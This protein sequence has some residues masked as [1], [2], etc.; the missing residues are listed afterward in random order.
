MTRTDPRKLLAAAAVLVAVVAALVGRPHRP[1]GRPG[2]AT[3]TVHRFPVQAVAFSPDGATLTTAAFFVGAGEADVT[4]WDVRAGCPAAR[5]TLP[6]GG[7][8]CLAFAPGGRPLAAA[9]DAL[10]V[11][12]WDA[13]TGDETRLPGPHSSVRALAFSG[14]GGRLAAADTEPEGGVAVSVV[15]GD[16]PG[17]RCRGPHGRV[18][19]LAFSPDGHTLAGGECDGEPAV[20]L[21]DAGTG[22]ERAACRGHAAGVTAVAFA[23]DGR[24]LASG[25]LHGVV[26]LWDAGTGA[27]RATLTAPGGEAVT[28]V[29]F[30]PDGRT[31]AVAA[32]R[33]V[34]LWDPDTGHIAAELAGHTGK[35]TCL[36]YSPD[37]SRLATGGYD[38]TARVWDVPAH[39]PVR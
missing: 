5:R 21:W 4:D 1:A 37:G 39:R 35:V 29:G 11:R 8:R 31:L 10:G 22:A 2:A 20:R 19:A 7:R 6:G 26:K 30:A 38:R 18:L 25:D 15:A 32:G 24:T 3:L 36:A 13:D 17:F 12:L 28:A 34:R 9:G 23:P 33:V 14:D 16:R 27:E